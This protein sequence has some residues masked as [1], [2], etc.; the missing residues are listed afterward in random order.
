MQYG[1]PDYAAMA[2]AG[3]PVAMQVDASGRYTYAQV[4]HEHQAKQQARR[5]PELS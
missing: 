3:M 1:Q 4:Y 5:A 2:Q